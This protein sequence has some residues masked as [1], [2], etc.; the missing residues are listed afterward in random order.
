MTD[1]TEKAGVAGAM[2]VASAARAPPAAFWIG[3]PPA[4]PE[5]TNAPISAKT[6]LAA[7][8]IWRTMSFVSRMALLARPTGRIDKLAY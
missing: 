2:R 4:A 3:V 1:H 7:T 5:P 6:A 8:V